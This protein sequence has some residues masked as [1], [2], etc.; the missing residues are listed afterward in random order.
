MMYI[1]AYVLSL[2]GNETIQCRQSYVILYICCVHWVRW[3][4]V[5]VYNTT[6][7]VTNQLR[8]KK[9]IYS[10][11]GKMVVSGGFGIQPTVCC[12]QNTYTNEK[13]QHNRST[14]TLSIRYCYNNKRCVTSFIQHIIRFLWGASIILHY[15]HSWSVCNAIVQCKIRLYRCLFQFFSLP[16]CLSS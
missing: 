6:E 15:T 3:C 8:R 4:E 16:L 1:F 13:H 7:A 2:N 10:S 11:S 5:P 12:V 9:H 14:W